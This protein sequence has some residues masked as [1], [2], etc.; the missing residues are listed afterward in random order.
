MNNPYLLYLEKLAVLLTQYSTSVERGHYVAIRYDSQA[1][2]LALA[3]YRQVL[4]LGA[5]A[6]FR[7]NPSGAEAAFFELADE[8][9]LQFTDIEGRCKTVWLSIDQIDVAG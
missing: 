5:N 6:V 3:V 2:P 1:E 7:T 8:E 4:K 9:Q